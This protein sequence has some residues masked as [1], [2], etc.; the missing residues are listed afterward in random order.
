MRL[1]DIDGIRGY[2]GIFPSVELIMV[3]GRGSAI[4]RIEQDAFNTG[5]VR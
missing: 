2:I 4:E 1:N 5:E 3:R